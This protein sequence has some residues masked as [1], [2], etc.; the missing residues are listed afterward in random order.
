MI[1][2]SI[3]ICHFIKR[4]VAFARVLIKGT[5]SITN[6]IFRAIIDQLSGYYTIPE[7]HLVFYFR[8]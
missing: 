2:L 1:R 7:E 8:L 6:S 4:F 5:S 3:N